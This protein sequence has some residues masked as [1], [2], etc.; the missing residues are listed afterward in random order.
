LCSETAANIRT[1]TLTSP[2]EIVPD[3]IARGT[4]DLVPR[5]VTSVTRIPSDAE[6]VVHT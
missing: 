1:G 3:Q 6:A 5:P 4:E 2:K